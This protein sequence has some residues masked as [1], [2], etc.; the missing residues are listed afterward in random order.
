V[1]QNNQQDGLCLILL[2][3]LVNPQQP[4]SE[5]LI[6]Q[7]EEDADENGIPLLTE[8]KESNLE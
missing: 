1:L 3:G 8:H 6:E 7:K 2:N 5:P 4:E